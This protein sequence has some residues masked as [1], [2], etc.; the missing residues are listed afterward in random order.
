MSPATQTRRITL[1]RTWSAPIE[2][3]WELWTTKDGLES[4]WGPDG[5]EVKVRKLDLRVGGE[6]LYAMIAIAE[7]QIAFLKK[8]GMPVIQEARIQYTEVE[9]MRRLAYEHF[10]DFVPGVKAY[11]TSMAIDLSAG[12]GGVKMTVTIDAM[13]DEKWTQMAVAGWETEF[14]KLAKALQRKARP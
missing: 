13:H 3:I 9:P 14:G 8:A 12:P 2:D 5:F 7:P 1:E 4:W 6:L 10:V 11:W